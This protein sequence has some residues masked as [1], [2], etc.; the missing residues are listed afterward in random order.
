MH[1]IKRL[2]SELITLFDNTVVNF[3]FIAMVGHVPNWFCS[4]AARSH[5][6]KYKEF[7]V[8]ELVS[9]KDFKS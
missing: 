1:R 9:T 6:V 2:S 5:C 4:Q 7:P 3:V 8:V